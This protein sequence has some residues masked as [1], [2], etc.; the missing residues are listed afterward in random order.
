MLAYKRRRTGDRKNHTQA[1]IFIIAMSQNKNQ[2]NLP[3]LFIKIADVE[4]NKTITNFIIGNFY[5]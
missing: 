3:E 1:K 5:E 2:V 4:F